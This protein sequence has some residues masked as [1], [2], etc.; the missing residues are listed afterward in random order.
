MT[1]SG[2]GGEGW[3]GVSACEE[4]AGRRLCAQ[5]ECSGSVVLLFRCS[6]IRVPSFLRRSALPSSGDVAF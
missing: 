5:E 1:K 4:G 3:C 6:I 2:V